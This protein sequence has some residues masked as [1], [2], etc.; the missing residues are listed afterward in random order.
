[1]IDHLPRF[2]LLHMVGLLPMADVLRMASVCRAVR[3]VA[4]YEL[5]RESAA[6]VA[7]IAERGPAL[8]LCLARAQE[9]CAAFGLPDARPYGALLSLLRGAPLLTVWIDSGYCTADDMRTGKGLDYYWCLGTEDV[10]AFGVQSART[11]TCASSVAPDHYGITLVCQ[12]QHDEDDTDA[13]WRPMAGDEPLALLSPETA[14]RVRFIGGPAEAVFLAARPVGTSRL[15]M[16]THPEHFAPEHFA[17]DAGRLTVRWELHP[18]G[19]VS[20]RCE[21][22][23]CVWSLSADCSLSVV[24]T[25][26]AG[27]SRVPPWAEAAR[28]AVSVSVFGKLD[29]YEPT[30]RAHFQS[31]GMP[32]TGLYLGHVERNR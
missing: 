32:I 15:W 22:G 12:D 30:I 24:M 26:G 9:A 14:V 1:M 10:A 17:P 27:A 4:C 5:G 6:R 13:A 28:G 21:P 18:L 2:V 31:H 23:A 8:G 7:L 20:C 16:G 11:C 3:S 29:R 25:A 19:A